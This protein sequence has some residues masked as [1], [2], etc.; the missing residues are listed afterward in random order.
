MREAVRKPL[1]GLLIVAG[2]VLYAAL[3]GFA[4][5]TI[6]GWHVLAQG[7][8]YLVLGIIWVPAFKPLVRWIET[9]RF[10]PPPRAANPP[11]KET[12]R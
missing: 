10:T 2:L 12:A 9:G 5:G 11:A 4:S 7:L 6:G 3:V 1:G 8:A